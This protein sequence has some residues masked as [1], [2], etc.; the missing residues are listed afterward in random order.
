[1]M[2]NV[3]LITSCPRWALAQRLEK[4]LKKPDQSREDGPR[5]FDVSIV[6]Y[7]SSVCWFAFGNILLK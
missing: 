3:T 5:P 4:D 2:E 7:S 6:S 1:M